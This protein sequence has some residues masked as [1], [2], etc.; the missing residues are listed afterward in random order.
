[1]TTFDR[2]YA[3]R[4]GRQGLNKFDSCQP[5]VGMPIPCEDVLVGLTVEV[6]AQNDVKRVYAVPNPYRSG[7]SRLTRQNYHN[8]PDN[9]VRFVNVPPLATIRIFTVAGDL[10]WE[11]KHD[12]FD[13][14]IEWDVRNGSGEIVASG[15]YIYKI[16]AADGDTVF[17]RLVVIR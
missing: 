6:D 16:E 5:Q 1:V 2:D 17:G 3:V 8:F 13:G 11:G 7:G 14:N 9:M 15:V 10:V 4:S 12:G